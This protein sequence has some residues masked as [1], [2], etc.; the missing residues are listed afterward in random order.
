MAREVLE[1]CR[2]Q[3]VRCILHNFVEI[4]ADLHAEGI[5]LPLPLLLR[6]ER[7]TLLNFSAVGAS[8]HSREEA[9]LAQAHGC[10]YLTAGHVFD[11]DCKKGLPGRGTDFLKEVCKE[12]FLPVYAIGGISRD[13]VD[14]VRATGAAGVC[15]MSG[16]MRCENVENYLLDIE[17]R[18]KEK[19]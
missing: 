8:C 1:I 10:T 15:V 4:A 11:T 9:R 12:V 6:T 19:D 17:A 5:H 13:N 3:G 16:V 14:R 18:A 2:A 7:K